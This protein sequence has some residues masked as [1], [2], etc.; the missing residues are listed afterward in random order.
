MYLSSI[1]RKGLTN[2]KNRECSESM[3][4]FQSL[5]L[6]VSS[7]LY[8]ILKVK[9]LLAINWIPHLTHEHYKVN[10]YCFYY[11]QPRRIRKISFSHPSHLCAKS[12]PKTLHT[13]SHA[14]APTYT[15]HV[16]RQHSSWDIR[17]GW[18]RESACPHSIEYKWTSL[19]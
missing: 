2:L 7:F 5:I 17:D 13:H 3:I 12:F 15:V 1:S 10:Y 18:A 16:E 9:Y 8:E 4:K 6:V 11:Y 19:S 14:E